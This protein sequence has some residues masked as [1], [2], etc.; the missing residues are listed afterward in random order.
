M[1]V[2]LA[3]AAS[4][5]TRGAENDALYASYMRAVE[6][7]GL[8]TDPGTREILQILPGTI[9]FVDPLTGPS[10]GGRLAAINADT[11]PPH[12]HES[13]V[14][15]DATSAADCS[16]FG[17]I[18]SYEDDLDSNDQAGMDAYLAALNADDL[19]V[20]PATYKGSTMKVSNKSAPT[21]AQ[22]AA[23]PAYNEASPNYEIYQFELYQSGVLV[24]WM[25]REHFFFADG[26]QGDRDHWYFQAGYVP[27]GFGG[28]DVVAVPWG[29]F[30]THQLFLGAIPLGL[31][32]TYQPVT[33][34]K[35]QDLDAM[36]P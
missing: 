15:F 21:P 22:I 12:F 9:A 2:W 11:P 18:L 26:T 23:L 19:W 1:W 27:V 20:L 5:Q 10:L 29:A 3:V 34:Y 13:M 17:F 36:V 33:L 7:L 24:G 28:A 25:L 32:T 4:A 8:A 6:G 35:S 31:V 16:T 30:A 14:M